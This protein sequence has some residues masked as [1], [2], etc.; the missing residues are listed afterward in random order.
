MARPKAAKRPASK[1]RSQRNWQPP[2]WLIV[3]FLLALV[4]IYFYETKQ[5][6]NV[7]GSPAPVGQPTLSNGDLQ[8]FF[9]TTDLVYPDRRAARGPSG[10]LQ[11]V[12][13]DINA[14]KTSIDLATFDFDVPQVTDAL[15]AAK[16]RGATVRLIV[17]SENLSTPEVAQETGRLQDARIPVHFDN[18]EPFMHNKFLV[19]DAAIIWAGSWNLTENDTYRNNNNMVRF[20][21]REM[22]RNYTHEFGKMFDGAF[23]TAKVSDTPYPHLRIGASEVA[24]YFSPEDGVAQYVLERIRKAQH[25]IRFMTFSFTADDISAAM[26]AK[27]QAGLQVTGVFESQNATGSGA[28]FKALR[29]GKIDVLTDGNCYILHHK[30]IIIDDQTVITGSYNFTGSAE[31]D[32]DENLIIVDDPGV[33]RSYIEEFNRVYQQ[34]QTPL[35]CG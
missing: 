5:P 20:N 13:A 11:K 15:L 31:H 1:P 3:L 25:T 10:L 21:N 32:N 23:G 12:L 28:E 33:A 16:K 30:V 6:A 18:R 19:V 29:A 2:G 14:A 24:T 4:L 9:T 34:A 35:R 7:P 17:D 27:K 22:A 8:T 26:V